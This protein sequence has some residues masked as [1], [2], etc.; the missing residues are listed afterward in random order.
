MARRHRAWRAIGL[1]RALALAAAAVALA[2][3]PTAAWAQDKWPARRVTLVVPFGAGTVTDAIG[4]LLA[5]QLKDILGQPFIV[6]NRAGAGGMLGAGVV[7]KAAPDGYTILMGGNTTHSA[8]PALF[9]NVPYDPM[10]D[11][12]PIARIGRFPSMLATNTQQPFKTVHEFVA[13]ARANP[14]KLTCGHGNATGHI[15]CETVK[16][17]LSLEIVRLPYTSNPPAITDLLGNNIQLMVPDFLGGLPHVKAGKLVAL[18][19][20]MLERSPELPDVPTFHETVIKDF[21]VSPWT[22]LI[23]PAGLPADVVKLLSDATGRILASPETAS[24]IKAMGTE[25]W[26]MPSE[27]FTRFVREDMPV[28]A[29]H[30][31]TAGID[32]Q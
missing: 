3:G 28:W 15:V 16:R 27:P 14:G 18:A 10:K 20:V 13:F 31:R 12:T 4:R 5:D 8:A 19:V 22:S 30:A 11:F 29:A 2:V 26:Y 32:P 21:E 23:G 7:A 25:L 9:K 24:K 6:E 1:T 17:R